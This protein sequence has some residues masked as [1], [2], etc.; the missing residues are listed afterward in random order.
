MSDVQH[1]TPLFAIIRL[2]GEPLAGRLPRF[3]DAVSA[4]FAG[5][6]VGGVRIT[7]RRD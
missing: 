1:K 3:Y 2:H 7:G 6:G 5:G 4:L